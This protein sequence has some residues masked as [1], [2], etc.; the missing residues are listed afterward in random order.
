MTMGL[1][2]ARWKS[3]TPSA[4]RWEQDALTF[5]RERLPD[6]DPYR[7]WSNFEFIADDGTI[8]EVDLL[9]LSPVGLFLVE[10]KSWPGMLRGDLMTWVIEHDGRA[11]PHDNPL[12]LANRKAK[13]LASLL[14]RQKGAKDIRVPF[15][16]P[17][18]F[19]SHENMR[20][21]LP[22][23]SRT[24]VTVRDRE[25][26]GAGYPPGIIAALTTR[27]FDG[28]TD[29]PHTR[30]DRPV[31]KAVITAIEQAGIRESNRSRRVG[32]YLL[33]ELLF[34]APNGVYQDWLGEHVQSQEVRWVRIYTVSR[35][36]S[37]EDRELTKR[38]ASREYNI[39]KDVVHP[40]LP[41]VETPV[42]HDLGTALLF[43]I[44]K[45]AIRLDHL[46]AQKGDSLSADVRLALVRQIAE[47]LKYVHEKKFYHRALSP[48][49]VFVTKFDTTSP[50]VQIFN[51]QASSREGSSSGASR[52]SATRHIEDLVESAS[53]AYV[54]PE[55]LS[56]PDAAGEKLD[57]FSLGA[58]AYFI[59]SGKAPATSPLELIEKIR[60]GQGLRI[61]SVLDGAGEAMQELIQLST[62][63]DTMLRPDSVD[64]FLKL[65]DA[66]E[67]ELTKP[68]DDDEVANPL[69][70][71]KDHKLPGGYVVKRRLGKGSSATAFLV[72]RDKR[73]VVLKL[74]NGPEKN[75][76]I[77]AE[78][79]TLKKLS[80]PNIAQFFEPVMFEKAN[81][82]GFTMEYA[83]ERNPEKNQRDLD[84]SLADRLRKEG[85]LQLELLENLG[86]DLI[87]AVRYLEQ[88]GVAHRDIKPENAGVGVGSRKD[89]TRLVLYDF[90]LSRA[91]LTEIHAG[92]PPYLDPYLPFRP[93]K[94]WDSHAER[95][96]VAMTLYEMTTGSTPKFSEGNPAA[97]GTEV[98][99]EAERFDA[100]LRDRFTAFFRKGFRS[101]PAERFDNADEMLGAWR[102]IFRNV[103]QPALATITRDD[104]NLEEVIAAA[105][106]ETS[107]LEFGLSARAANALDRIGVRTAEELLRFSLIKIH[108]QR[109]VG[110]KTRREI[111]ELVTKLR[112]RF[113]DLRQESEPTEPVPL[114]G[115][116]DGEPEVG[117]IDLIVK[118]L[119]GSP[120]EQEKAEKKIL[121]HFLGVDLAWMQTPFA[122]KNQTEVG[123]RFGLT[124]ARIG[125]VVTKGRDRW[126][127]NA[128][129]RSV[130]DELVALLDSSGGVLTVREASLAIVGSRGSSEVDPVRAQHGSSVVRT[131]LE[132]ESTAAEP[133]FGDRRFERRLGD[134]VLIARSPEL[135]D[136]AERLGR[137]ADKLAAEEPLAAPA[138]VVETLRQLYVNRRI[139]LPPGVQPMTDARLARL[140]V[141]TSMHAALSSKGEIYPRGMDAERALNLASGALYGAK[142]LTVEDIQN[143][144]ASR[145]PEAQPL[146]RRPELDLLLEAQNLSLE[147]DEASEQ[148]VYQRPDISTELSGSSSTGTILPAAA[149]RPDSEERVSAKLFEERLTHALADGGFL[150]LTTQPKKAAVA[151]RKLAARFGLDVKNLDA[152]VI[153][154]MRDEAQENEVDW[155]VVVEADG[156]APRSSARNNL[157]HLVSRA[158]PRILERMKESRTPL[159]SYPGLLARYDR[160][161]L[162]EKLRD[163]AGTR[164]SPVHVAWL[165]VAADGQAGR[166]VVDGMPVPILSASQWAPIPDAWVDGVLEGQ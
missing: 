101:N 136:L 117:S 37:E 161:D 147:W 141:E 145:Y 122:W 42:Q 25:N 48:Q 152:I 110:T 64:D 83:G 34:D 60:Q 81:L 75:D 153:S 156:A 166:P 104:F 102:E 108:R 131:A 106:P 12:I 35:A 10:I 57:A 86:A 36:A 13:K 134:L 165:L 129:I 40:S 103:E 28:A 61:S 50:Q 77:R 62:H 49:S 46:F 67:D 65:L 69:D 85:A 87:E 89:R 148:Y 111:V 45:N 113:P 6:L 127:R 150:V 124:R 157:A 151:E 92:T 5:V 149:Y 54:A 21:H 79:E 76:R 11:H 121:N 78:A 52:V 133:R 154:A 51:W 140:A 22:T 29:T 26:A 56:D 97:R 123:R 100:T 158:V 32:D 24:R 30:I 164:S 41:P 135:A 80:H 53:M 144:V 162:I 74:A 16:E 1:S 73:E 114:K 112:A 96:A 4:Y 27:A 82:A 2:D 132:A 38:A 146:P 119:I 70:A 44:Q 118:Q 116:D 84:A 66:V 19:L 137:S 63:P 160:M 88:K 109:G 17:L 99:V 125:Q 128:S 139:A 3:I 91:P 39:L 163:E 33:K 7:V 14:R 95:Y 105:T 142:R 59:F 18:I 15:I 98:P 120:R 68:G 55:S 58:I 31:F 155:N 47:V 90:S 94:M 9:V 23:G 159:F 126:R 107:V 8:N 138:R 72:E 20:C 115:V 130:R 93:K 71:R 43:R 143:R